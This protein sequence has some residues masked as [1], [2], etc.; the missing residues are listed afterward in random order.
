MDTNKDWS[1]LPDHKPDVDLWDRIDTE[2]DLEAISSQLD[3][4]PGHSPKLGLWESI[5]HKLFIHQYLKFF[6]FASIGIVVAVLFFV[7]MNSSD[8]VNKS[9]KSNDLVQ[10]LSISNNKMIKDIKILSS[11]NSPVVINNKSK[12]AIFESQKHKQS[13]PDSKI[14]I[15]PKIPEIQTNNKIFKTNKETKAD[16]FIKD[17]IKINPTILAK[18]DLSEIQNAK[19]KNDLSEKTSKSIFLIDENH[20]SVKN[21][22]NPISEINNKLNFKVQEKEKEN[23]A[24]KPIQFY[25]DS[26]QNAINIEKTDALGADP[27]RNQLKS[28]NRPFKNGLYTIGMDYTISKIYNQDKFSYSDIDY[29]HQYGITL[30]YNYSHWCLQTGI[31]F[32]KFTNHLN[33]NSDQQFN[34]YITYNYV[35]SVIYNSQGAIVQYITH[36]VTFNDSV[37]FHELIKTSKKYSYL[38]LPLMAGYQFGYGKF[39]ISL[40]AG[41]LCSFIISEKEIMLIPENPNIK[42]I[43]IYSEHSSLNRINWSGLLSAAIDYHINKKWGLTVE[44]I[45]QY[46]FKPIYQVIDLKSNSNNLSPY[47][48]GIKTGLFYKF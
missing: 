22:L 23:N 27:K 42:V 32:S 26:N 9:V 41:V 40:K 39:S 10:G 33:Y 21:T 11:A 29:L 44:P 31:N 14:G 1:N 19:E 5:N 35:D 28:T 37:L 4:L 47:L 20:R 30:K 43:K 6:Y 17:H 16:I 34:Q 12:K 15:S 2:L 3:Q 45:F 25:S 18:K 8:D 7:F 46:Y 38:H 13:I 36:P 24:V 48:I